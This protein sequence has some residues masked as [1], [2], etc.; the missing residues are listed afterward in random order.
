MVEPE[1]AVLR[2]GRMRG[3]VCFLIG[4]G[5]GL[6]GVGLWREEGDGDPNPPKIPLLPYKVPGVPGWWGWRMLTPVYGCGFWVDMPLI[7]PWR[8]R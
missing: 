5:I 7:A 3:L 2:R 6:L 8:R 1:G 4:A